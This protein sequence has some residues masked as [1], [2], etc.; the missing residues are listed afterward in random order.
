MRPSRKTLGAPGGLGAELPPALP[1]PF[2]A[3]AAGG[4][5][6]RDGGLRVQDGGRPRR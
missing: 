5:V 2:A 1:F 6:R 4:L 3:A